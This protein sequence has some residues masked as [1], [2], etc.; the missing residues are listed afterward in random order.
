[1]KLYSEEFF[2][3]LLQDEG[4]QFALFGADKRL[5][6]ASIGLN[7]FLFS[8]PKVVLP[9]SKIHDLFPELLGYEDSLQEILD[10]SL[11][12]IKIERVHRAVLLGVEG[13]V[14]LQVRIFQGG[15]LVIV[16][17]VT[18]EG[19][20]EQKVTQQRNELRLEVGARQRAEEALRM[21]NDQLEIRVAERTTE[22]QE[23]YVRL[24]T[25]SRR[26]VQVQ[27]AERRQ[28][29]RELHDEIG[30]ALTGIKLLL[31]MSVR[32]LPEDAKSSLDEAQSL[33]VDLIGQVRQISLDLRPA[34]LDDLGLVPALLWHF[35]RY[36]HQTGVDVDFRHAEVNRRFDPNVE[37]AAY[38]IIQEALTNVARYAKTDQVQVRLSIYEDML[39][40]RIED[41]GVGFDPELVMTRL[42]SNGL[43]GMQERAVLL[44]GE[45][46]IESSP[47]TGTQIS[48]E[49]PISREEEVL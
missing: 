47:G 33:V 38:R 23:A 31:G 30:Q 45:L 40:L 21:V 20:L 39:Y 13:Y 22:L 19:R 11:P 4:I 37:T 26:L 44:N 34:M 43:S 9:A 18:A 10:G 36:S 6:D 46:I 32:N 16:Y 14:T 49:L 17:D 8:P 42:D 1:V 41:Q 28:I 48:V 27:E 5:L 29:A 12:E 3:E 15:W 35:E 25:L 7:D 2:T 24:Q